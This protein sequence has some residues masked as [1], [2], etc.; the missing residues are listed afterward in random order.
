MGLLHYL[1]NKFIVS[2]PALLILTGIG[3]EPIGA[4]VGRLGAVEIKA[5]YTG[6]YEGAAY[7]VVLGVIHAVIVGSC[8]ESAADAQ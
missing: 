3:V 7:L 4:A 5:E 2:Y 6:R 1:L 8:G